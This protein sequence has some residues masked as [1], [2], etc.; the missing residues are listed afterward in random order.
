MQALSTLSTPE[1][2]LAV[3]CKKYIDLLEDNR[4]NQ[5]GMKILKK[6]QAQ[7]MKETVHLHSKYSKAT[8][9]RSKLKSLCRELQCHNKT[10]K[11]ENMQQ[12]REEEESHRKATSHFQ[13]TLN[14]IEVQLERCEIHNTKLHQENIELREKLKT[15]TGRC[16]LSK[17]DIDKVLNRKGLEQQL[18][19]KLQQTTQLIQETDE[20]HQREREFLL[21]EATESRHKYEEIKRQEVHLKQQI[22]LY[23]DKFEDFQTILTRRSELFTTFRQEVEKMT[24]KTAKMEKKMI[25][26]R[27]KWEDNNK[28]LLQ[29]AE[30]KTIRDK[31]YMASQMKLERLEKLF[32]AL[33]M[34]RNE[35]C[36]KVE[37]LKKKDSVKEADVNLA[38]R[39]MQPRTALESQKELNTSSERAP[40]VYLRVEPK[41][42]KKAKCGSK[43]PF[44]MI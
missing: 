9:V 23:M 3:L 21:K 26:W 11:E 20:K 22:S 18:V 40:G 28:V 16:T 34:E 17:E 32:R 15:L 38:T 29:M 44:H 19:A 30:E 36:E 7:I 14:E 42:V 24:K 25:V 10:L 5:R 6:T 13:F 27:S 1:E 33:Q 39:V 37:V 8:L 2:K 43:A 12:A 31:E 4:N 35:L 41:S